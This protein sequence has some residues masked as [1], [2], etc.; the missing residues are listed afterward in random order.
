MDSEHIHKVLDHSHIQERTRIRFN[1]L[2]VVI[3]VVAV[4]SLCWLFLAY[5]KPEN[6]TAIIAL[7]I[8]LLGGFGAGRAYEKSQ[9]Q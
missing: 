2:V 6:V 7:V 3:G 8:G 5:D 9:S 1:L 4:F